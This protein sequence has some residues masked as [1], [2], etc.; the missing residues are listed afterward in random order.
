[1]AAKLGKKCIIILINCLL[2]TSIIGQNK[3]PIASPNQKID[4]TELLELL[5]AD[6]KVEIAYSKEVL[7][8]VKVDFP[9]E[10][11]SL[12]QILETSLEGT[13]LTFKEIGNGKYV[14]GPKPSIGKNSPSNKYT[15]KG[16]V[17]NPDNRPLSFAN[18]YCVNE[19]IGTTSDEFGNFEL[20]CSSTQDTNRLK[21]SFV[22]YQSKEILVS[23]SDQFM[24]VRLDLNPIEFKKITITRS[25][26]G[27]KLDPQDQSMTFRP[28]SMDQL[29]SLAAGGD[30][31]RNLQLLPGI[32]GSNDLSAQL[33]IRGGNPDNNLVMLDG[34]KLYNVDHFYG[35]YSAIHP[36]IIEE[37]NIYKNSFPIEYSGNTASVV[38]ML[39]SPNFEVLEKA[40]LELQTDLSTV[41]L[42]AQLPLNKKMGIEF[43]GRTTYRDIANSDIFEVFRSN[44]EEVAKLIGGG[45]EGFTRQKFVSIVPSF[46]FYDLYGKWS[47]TPGEKDQ[48]NISVFNGV[49][50]LN[51]KYENSFDSFLD[52]LSSNNERNEND[53]Q[54]DNFGIGLNYIRDWN[55]KWSSTF[56]LSRSSY[57]FSS[58][59]VFALT[60][61]S[62]SGNTNQENFRVLSGFLLDNQISGLRFDWKHDYTLHPD[63]KFTFGYS[64]VQDETSADVKNIARNGR[65]SFQNKGMANQHI[66]YKN[67][68]ASF[69]DKLFVSAGLSTTYYSANEAIYFSPRFQFN[70]QLPLNTA[71]KGAWSYNNQFLR[72]LVHEN[73]WGESRNIWILSKDEIPVATSSNFMLGANYKKGEIEIDLELYHKQLGGVANY[74]IF[75]PGFNADQPGLPENNNF[76]FF[77]GEGRVRGLDLMIKKSGKKY[78]TWI[79]YTLSKN[80]NRFESINKGNYY[81]SQDDKRHQF[82]LANLYKHKKWSFSANYIFAS[83]TPYLDLSTLNDRPQNRTEINIEDR[84]KRVQDYHRI[85]IGAYFN[86]PINK[87]KAQI[88]LSVFNLLNTQNVQQPQF[89]FSF[90]EKDR[91][92]R[93]LRN[94]VVGTE[95]QMLGRTPNLE[96]KISF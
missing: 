91:E 75:T 22:G 68:Q 13:H 31:M 42:H 37:V 87:S 89:L 43:A 32:D 28:S 86:F 92:N 23:G 57:H 36:G 88:G 11:S 52:R 50:Q 30:I 85:D 65:D 3:Q 61:N 63:H 15:L 27:L 73:Y 59:R 56:N 44:Q 48:L 24:E 6:K 47:W 90:K 81:S 12:N 16:R 84:L 49:D 9:A 53:T 67:W 4:L 82:K 39:T 10:S 35:F 96:F 58:E 66:L 95:L 77:Y 29:P 94:T 51:Y 14:V 62:S 54:W 69:F 79:A 93:G 45:M 8:N 21:V 74:L 33:K 55:S 70:Y 26:P 60:Q 40:K 18:I 34:I 1:M 83:G 19:Q 25:L 41:G 17:L 78:T 46:K 76:R 72:Q 64:F 7:Q 80:E 38:E 2:W 20:T 71:I 5:K